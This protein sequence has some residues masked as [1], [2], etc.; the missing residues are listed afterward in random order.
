M[1][2]STS[3]KKLSQVTKSVGR[4]AHN[5]R[6]INIGEFNLDVEHSTSLQTPPSLN[7]QNQFTAAVTKMMMVTCW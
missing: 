6:G 5:L 2:E 4:P 1:K 3:P 7:R